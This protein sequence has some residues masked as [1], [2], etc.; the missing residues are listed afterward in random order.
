MMSSTYNVSDAVF[1][2][3]PLTPHNNPMWEVL[4]SHFIG[5]ETKHKGTIALTMSIMVAYSVLDIHTS[6]LLLHLMEIGTFMI[7]WQ[8]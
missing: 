7:R 4:V 5:E 8:I 6:V 2:V 1:S 3:L